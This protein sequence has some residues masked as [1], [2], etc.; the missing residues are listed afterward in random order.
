M[1]DEATRGDIHPDDRLE[2]LLR[3]FAVAARAHHEALESMDEER[4]ETQARMLAALHDAVVREGQKG[5]ES[6]LKLADSLDPVVAGMAAV[7]SIRLD[8]RRCLATLR[9]VAKEPG[10]LGF[11]ADMAIQRWEAGEWEV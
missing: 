7:Y 6:L 3:R 1:T 5:E 10:L 8:T 11:R 9:R 2:R 4:A